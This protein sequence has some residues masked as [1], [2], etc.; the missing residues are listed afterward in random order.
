MLFAATQPLRL[1]RASY[2]CPNWTTKGRTAVRLDL[3]A[4]TSSHNWLHPAEMG[5]RQRHRLQHQS[6]YLSWA[7]ALHVQ[8]ARSFK[9]L[10]V[11]LRDFPI[12]HFTNAYHDYVL[13]F[14]MTSPYSRKPEMSHSVLSIHPQHPTKDPDCWVYCMLAHE[15]CP[16]WSRH[17][18]YLRVGLLHLMTDVPCLF[19]GCIEPSLAAKTMDVMSLHGC[20]GLLWLGNTVVVSRESLTLHLFL[21]FSNKGIWKN[22]SL[23]FQ[24]CGGKCAKLT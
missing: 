3:R 2:R 5:R 13:L 22:P 4:M 8:I 18:P 9:K 1:C 10:R 20:Q 23:E 19:R 24:N 11:E 7:M 17:I 6:P 16:F 14:F 21:S 15:T 12:W